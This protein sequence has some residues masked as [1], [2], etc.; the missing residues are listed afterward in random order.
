MKIAHQKS[1]VTHL[2]M[3]RAHIG[4]DRP[5]IVGIVDLAHCQSKEAADQPNG[6]VGT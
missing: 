1:N 6:S 2:Y 3:S 4:A 5:I